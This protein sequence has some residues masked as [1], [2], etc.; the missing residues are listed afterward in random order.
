M[1]N[2][3]KDLDEANKHTPQGFDNAP[4]NN[5]IPWKDENDL[6]TYT[7]N[8]KLPRAI[9]FVD[10]TAVAPTTVDGAIYVIIGSGVLDASWGTL[11]AFGDWV[12]FANGSAVAITPAIGTLCFDDTAAAWKEYDGTVWAVSGGGA[13]SNLYTADGTLTALRTVT[14]AGFGLNL[15]GG[16]TTIKGA[17]AT[18]ATTA[19]LVENSAG[20]DLFEVK[21]DGSLIGAFPVELGSG[22][23]SI[24]QGGVNA[25]ASGDR[26]LA[27]GLDSLAG[28]NNSIAIGQNAIISGT[29][30][31]ASITIGTQ[32]S[33]GLRGVT[34][35]YQATSSSKEAV[36]I[37]NGANS[38]G[39]NGIAI[40]NNADAGLNGVAIGALTNGS[41]IGSVAIGTYMSSTVSYAV[42]IGGS[43]GAK[44]NSTSNSV[45]F[46]FNDAISTIRLGRTV[47]SWINTSANLGIGLNTGISAKLHVKGTGAT[48]GTTALLVENSAGTDLLNVLDDGNVGIGTTA[49]TQRLQVAD[50][51]GDA[52]LLVSAGLAATTSGTAALILN[53]LRSDTG[54][55]QQTSIETL[56]NAAGL[57][58]MIFKTQP[59]S[60][61]YTER[62]R[63]NFNGDTGIGASTIG[64]RLHVKGSGATSGTVTFLTEN[65][66]GLDSFKIDDA[67]NLWL[68]GNT[69]I[70]FGFSGSAGSAA[71][72]RLQVRG[73]DQLDSSIGF[74]V[75]DSTRAGLFTINNAGG[76]LALGNFGLGF[77]SGTSPTAK[78][79]I[80][81]AA[82][83][84]NLWCENSAQ[85]QLLRLHDDGNLWL[86]GNTGIGFGL[87]GSAAAAATARLQVRGSDQ[88][89]GTKGFMVED[90]LRV[91]LFEVRNDGSLYTKGVAG[92]TGTGVYTNFTIK[93]GIITAAS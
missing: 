54:V 30:N 1:S 22:T 67:S 81:S 18:S 74:R 19:L 11:A 40:G 69:G 33:A 79:N 44:T 58:S 25:V 92:F 23:D 47:D 48:S 34:L 88:L 83:A 21:D 78:M 52:N 28:P 35:G 76:I 72:A 15:T 73:S 29:L 86:N 60:G 16:Q 91:A 65:S 12:R 32:S 85:V 26:S 82:S 55:G 31:T 20:T 24:Q 89:A 62:M 66:A 13:G 2:F 38:S 56:A 84:Y 53:S 70:G 75:E 10:G 93:N 8:F 41:A 39:T 63:I 4:S 51:T 14:M 57:G 87:S 9:N 36:T 71:T 49:P 50:T 61:V 64:A 59:S 68:Y 42:M 3:H 6:S 5:T 37:G 90:S 17:G 80:R 45:E 27:F 46:N 77:V 43:T 7:E